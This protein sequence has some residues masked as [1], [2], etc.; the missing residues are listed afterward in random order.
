MVINIYLKFSNQNVIIVSV[1]IHVSRYETSF[2]Q[3]V[4]HSIR[5]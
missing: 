1:S 3:L 5:F 4:S 2:L